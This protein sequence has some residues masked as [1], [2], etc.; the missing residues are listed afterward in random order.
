MQCEKEVTALS[1]EC[2]HFLFS[3]Y[4]TTT[5]HTSAAIDSKWTQGRRRSSILARYAPQKIGRTTGSSGASAPGRKWRRQVN[6][7]RA[8]WSKM[9]CG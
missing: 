4:A 6:Q 2:C 3:M 9:I 7:D 8:W 5:Y 1:N